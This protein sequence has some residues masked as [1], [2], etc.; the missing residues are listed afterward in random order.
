MI[1]AALWTLAAA[2]VLVY[3]LIAAQAPGQAT[4]LGTVF[5][6]VALADYLALRHME[7]RR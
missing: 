6:A 3:A 2:L 1:R 5:A 7:N 4:D